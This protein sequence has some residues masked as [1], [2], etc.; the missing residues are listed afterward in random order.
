MTR[1]SMAFAALLLMLA[2]CKKAK[3]AEP[4]KPPEPTA[5]PLALVS[6]SVVATSCPQVTQYNARAAEN[7]IRK[8]VEPCTQIPGGAAHFTATMLPGGQIQLA[9]KE[10]DP[11]GGTVPTCVVKNQ[12]THKI[13]LRKACV[14]QVEL[15]ERPVV[16]PPPSQAA[17]DTDP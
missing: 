1:R 7:A 4:P 12:L 16:A 5:P 13:F 14:F 2:S 11:V 6:A 3:P 8:L 17:S 9:S 15:E 10:G